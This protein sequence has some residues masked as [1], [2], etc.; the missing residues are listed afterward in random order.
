MVLWLVGAGALLIAML[1]TIA[2]GAIVWVPVALIYAALGYSQ[3]DAVTILAYTS[4][5]WLPL[6]FGAG[7]ATFLRFL[8]GYFT[9]DPSED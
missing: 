2:A 9:S 8:R 3:S 6:G 7:M 1:G 5:I 4:I